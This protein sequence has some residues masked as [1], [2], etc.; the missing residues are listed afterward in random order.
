MRTKLY[1]LSLTIER[2]SSKVVR[3]WKA[4]EVEEELEHC[5]ILHDKQ[6]PECDII[7]QN[8]DLDKVVVTFNPLNMDLHVYTSDTVDLKSKFIE[9]NEKIISKANEI[10]NREQKIVDDFRDLIQKETINLEAMKKGLSAS[11]YSHLFDALDNSNGKCSKC[12]NKISTIYIGKDQK[13]YCKECIGDIDKNTGLPKN[14]I[15]VFDIG[16]T[17]FEG[18]I[19]K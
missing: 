10:L 18:V 1:K 19:K 2:N 8:N 4:V 5:C 12:D 14:A 16:H 7:V 3:D 17:I 13:V 15:G 6:Y 9:L 11:T